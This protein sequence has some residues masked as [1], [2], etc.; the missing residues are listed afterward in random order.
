MAVTLRRIL[1]PLVLAGLA[2]LA[3]TH[4]EAAPRDLKFAFGAPILSLDPG[5]ASGTLAQTVR[6][7]MLE[8]LVKLN[9]ES[10][11]IEPLL[12][13]SWSVADDKVT[14]TFRLRPNVKFHDGNMLTAADVVAT[15]TRLTAPDSGLPRGIDLQIIKSMRDVDP[16]TV[17][18][19]T[20]TPFGPFL[21]TIAQDSAAILSK[22]SL[23]PPGQ[24]I[25]WK[26]V[27]TGPYRYGSHV[28][29][30]RRLKRRALSS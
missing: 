16:H 26:V 29:E 3:P 5:I 20:R 27:G 13:E 10:G 7:Q 4:V 24:R 6:F 21:Q 15:F 19:V 1:L 12:A 25:D 23:P 22:A 30:Q 14:W 9:A 18:I 28:A 2:V 8:P 17:E 11:G